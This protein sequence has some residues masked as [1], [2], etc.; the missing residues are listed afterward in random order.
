[1]TT[2]TPT[3][4]LLIR[5]GINDYIQKGLLAGRTPGVHLNAQGQAQ[6]AAL[7]ERLA[8]T[9]LAAI[10]SSPLER[11][12]ETAA[13]L[14]QRLGLAVH[15]LDGLSES[16]CGAWTG[17]P[18][19]E[20]SK[21]ETWKQVQVH[22][23][24][25]RFPGGESMAEIQARMI[26]TLERLQ[27][28]HP[29]QAIA[30][31]SHSDPIKLAVAYYLGMGLDLFQRLEVAPASITELEFTPWRTRLLRLNDCAHLPPPPAEAAPSA[32]PTQP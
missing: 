31:V 18:L 8:T 1:M 13:P 21:A 3:R 30:V 4:I 26:A 7:A 16:D 9:Q 14:A 23:S 29:G 15:Y 24:R 2:E 22:P 27:A 19:E 32:S 25:F 12:A 17:Q 10:Y 20:L 5:H 28:A 11:T 6:A